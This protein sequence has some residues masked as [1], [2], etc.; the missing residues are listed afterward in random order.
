[1]SMTSNIPNYADLFGSI[2]FK[3]GDE[4]R[5]VYS[6]AAYLADLLQLL[7]DE[8]DTSSIDFDLRREDIK[9]IDL[10][11]ENTT[12]LIPYLDIAN[13]VLEGRI[14]SSSDTVYETLENAAYPFNMPFS[15]DSEKLKNHLNHLGISAHELRHLFSTDTDDYTAVAREYLGL[16]QE[17]WDKVITESAN[18]SD[19]FDAYGYTDT[20]GAGADGF[21]SNLSVVST[22]IEATD[23]GA[24]EMLALLYQ[25]LYIEPSDHTDVEAGRENFYINTGLGDRSGYVA[26]TADETQIRWYDADDATPTESAIPIEWFARTSR[27]VRLA[28]K[29][30]LS[31]TDLDHVLRHCCKSS[32]SLP[33]ISEDTLV[34]LSQILYVHKTLEQPVEAVVAIL[35]KISYQ[36]RTNEALPQDQFNQIFNLPCVSI[37][38]KY[39]HIATETGDLPEQY[40]DTTYHEYTQD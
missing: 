7:D 20:E 21:V 9:A 40:A 33:A 18:D 19:T 29:T 1:M 37:D 39:F 16:S 10:D 30:G 36:G 38:E 5:S 23:L 25:N 14:A 17:M 3:K 22:F 8:F 4:H 35:S 11:A 27:F 15:L 6:P 2:D 26:L 31:F 32:D 34:Y 13:E 12:T 28:H 24:Q